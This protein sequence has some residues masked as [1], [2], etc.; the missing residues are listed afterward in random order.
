VSDSSPR[1]PEAEYFRLR[2]EWLRYKSHLVDRLT[3]LP[4]LAAVLEDVR[5]LVESRGTVDVTY[6]DLGRSGWQ[7][8]RLGWAAYDETIRR[9][10][11]RLSD[12]RATGEL[13]E[14]DIVCLYT[15]RSDR[16]LVFRASRPETTD[17]AIRSRG[18][19]LLASLAPTGNGAEAGG[20]VR[21]A[22][23]ESRVRLAPMVRSER[24]IHQAVTHAMLSSL[25]ERA[26]V[27][28]RR[29]EA[30]AA[31]I[32]RSSVRS[33]FHPIVRLTDRQ[34]VGFEALTRPVGAFAFESVE[35]MFAFAESTDLVTDFERLCRNTALRSLRQLPRD[36]M[37]FLNASAR[38]IE[39]PDWA[40]GTVERLLAD[41]GRSPSD[42]VVEL[43]ERL[44]LARNEALAQI[45]A[46]F[47]RRGYRVA[48]DDMGAGHAS[49]QSLA[50]LEPDFLK[51]DASLVRDIH[52]SAIKRGLLES[53]RALGEKMHARVIAEG[54]EQE[55]ERRT[56]AGLGVEL[57]QGF[58]FHKED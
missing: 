10:A 34:A 6:L 57:G 26:G 17:P 4:T 54:I 30:L 9:F 38:A 20:G 7:E 52:R 43:T 27:D 12:L 13:G 2:T 24:A 44:A 48:I 42:V 18:E 16:F 45:V 56:L 58:L 53:L 31:M 37:V 33:V 41:S 25:E 8:S 11:R 5:R 29:R 19:A 49:L 1:D 36:A 15:V 23:G 51:F 32:T 35:E 21:P 50:A 28:A 3:G 22:L 40:D 47:K 55:E 14:A 39:D 46:G